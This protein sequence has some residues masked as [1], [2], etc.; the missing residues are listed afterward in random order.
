MFRS[1]HTTAVLLMLADHPLFRKV[2]WVKVRAG[3]F[4]IVDPIDPGAILYLSERDYKL[5]IRVS[6]SQD[7][8]L[9]VLARPGESPPSA[10]PSGDTT[11][12]TSP[13]LGSSA[14]TKPKQP[15]AVEGPVPVEFSDPL[16]PSKSRALVP[17][18]RDQRKFSSWYQSRLARHLV[19][20]QHTGDSLV[21]PSVEILTTLILGW[22]SDL[23]FRSGG[24]SVTSAAL[25]KALLRFGQDLGRIL[26]TRGPQALILKMK[27][28][29]FFMNK[30]LGGYVEPD[31][32]LLGEP[33]GMARSGLP[34]IIPLLL[35]R[36]IAQRHY[37]TIRMMEGV[38][39]SYSAFK[40]THEAQDL[41][42]VTDPHPHIQA[43]KLSDFSDFCKY[44]F[45]PRV[46]KSYLEDEKKVSLLT[47]NLC[48]PADKPLSLPQRGGPNHSVAILGAPLDA[49]AW[50]CCPVH[51]PLEWARHVGDERTIQLIE[52][53]TSWARRRIPT[54]HGKVCFKELDPSES[55]QTSR[56]GLIP[57]PAGK[58]R[59]IAIVDYWTQRLMKPMHDWM[60]SVL[61][62]LP[63]D[64]TFN[65]EES[66]RSYVL[67]T[68]RAGVE[69][70][71]SI[72]L[73][74]ATDLIP[75]ELYEAVL[76]GVLPDETVDLWIH[77]LTDRWFLV[78]DSD[79]V[80]PSLRG[81]YVRYGR[82][83]PMGTLS[84]WASMALVHHALE[85][86]AAMKAG[87]DPVYFTMYRVLGD[88]NVTG[89]SAVAAKYREVCED[90][91]V[92]VSP[93][94]TLDGKLF[95]FASQVYLDGKNISPLSLKEE[96][97]VRSFSQ[98]LE[99]ALRAYSRGYMED[100]TSI[101][102]F[103]RLLIPRKHYVRAQA[104]W[105]KGKLGGVVQTAL[106]SAFGCAGR[107]LARLGFQ[108]SGSKPFLL[109][110]QDKVQALAGDQGSLDTE[111]ASQLQEIELLF[112]ISTVRRTI[113]ML[114]D[115]LNDL[116]DARI[117]Y[118]EWRD[119]MEEFDLLPLSW[120]KGPI[121][122]ILN[123][124]ERGYIPPAEELAPGREVLR[125]YYR[126]LWPI[127][128]DSYAPY[129]GDIDLG[130]PTFDYDSVMAEDLGF[131]IEDPGVGITF[132]PSPN[133]F[134]SF[135][136]TKVRF[137]GIIRETADAVQRAE[138]ILSELVKAE[139]GSDLVNPFG[140]PWDLVD[141]CLALVADL[142]RLPAFYTLG[143]LRPS[144]SPKDVDLLRSWVRQ[145]QAYQEVLRHLPLQC[146]F[147]AASVDPQDG[148]SEDEVAVQ[149]VSRAVIRSLPGKRGS[150]EP[151]RPK[152]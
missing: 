119:G 131:Q 45:W 77:L 105:E 13:S 78:P 93:A 82:G 145:I 62:C 152:G 94:K 3:Q 95:I 1:F 9:I 61:A 11:S 118:G 42:S 76:R 121:Q 19:V 112:A 33:V 115:R 67:Q 51:W 90:L 28:T 148:A 137:P 135:G 114:R 113:G 75:L 44:V 12:K 144:R 21:T 104:M 106:V 92:P 147:D 111:T 73:K 71:H 15:Q 17:R 140:G 7:S 40:G 80:V 88:D 98:R 149:S 5:Q 143:D 91:H 32:F 85:L 126:A 29:L 47:P 68:S 24:P 117:R 142:P 79:L 151:V 128:E 101:A 49:L 110:M 53:S 87:H 102:R 22:G 120:R 123:Y 81:R 65:Q 2:D 150:P 129:L 64:G 132:P 134:T 125:S 108:G 99:L 52:E 26:E 31:P 107:L 146:N 27:N 35:R 30:W 56:L 46:I 133:A 55:L 97:G 14:G 8:P 38:L 57:E 43:D 34:R 6:I 69:M 124:P 25:R 54:F 20:D 18:K 100:K 127:I 138:A 59:T 41:R 70:H 86:Y 130:A 50:D 139:K 89:D 36:L 74:S 84:S 83:Q 96:L 103:L 109:A 58:V 72:D 16:I 122:W 141:E 63:T 4:A 66:L 23:S 39:K 136:G 37:P 48:L 60:M 116:N 10:G